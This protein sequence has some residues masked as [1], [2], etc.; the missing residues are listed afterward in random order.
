MYFVKCVCQQAGNYLFIC[1]VWNKSRPTVDSLYRHFDLVNFVFLFW[2][3]KEK[4]LNCGVQHFDQG[5]QPGWPEREHLIERKIQ[6]EMRRKPVCPVDEEKVN[7]NPTE[8][9]TEP[10]TNHLQ[11]LHIF[12]AEREKIYFDISAYCW[13]VHGGS[14]YVIFRLSTFSKDRSIMSKLFNHFFPFAYPKHQIS[15]SLHKGR[16]TK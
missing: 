12:W 13:L 4:L 10:D 14:Q 2:N 16:H 5:G 15:M 3:S 11:I 8:Y 9:Q 6:R 1:H 7:W